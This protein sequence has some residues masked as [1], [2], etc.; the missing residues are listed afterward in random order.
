MCNTSTQ[1][2]V[3]HSTPSPQTGTWF[4]E[5]SPL[6]IEISQMVL[7]LSREKQEK[8]LAYAKALLVATTHIQGDDQLPAPQMQGRFDTSG[9]DAPDITVQ[10]NPFEK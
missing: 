8:V 4:P 9:A 2:T 3:T 7:R 5:E 10:K 1:I 6:V